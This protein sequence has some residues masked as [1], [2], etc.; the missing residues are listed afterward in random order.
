M[1]CSKANMPGQ[2]G[3][4]SDEDV[5]LSKLKPKSRRERKRWNMQTKA[6]K[7]N[8]VWDDASDDERPITTK[9]DRK[10]ETN[11]NK[12][13]SSNGINNKEKDLKAEDSSDDEPLVKKTKAPPKAAEERKLQD[14][15]RKDLKDKESSDDEP[16]VKIP[17][18]SSKPAKKT[19]SR[20]PKKSVNRKRKESVDDDD[21]DG[22][23]VGDGVDNDGNSD[24]EP[25]SKIAKK[26]RSGRKAPASPN[27][28]ATPVKKSTRNTARKQVKYVEPS[29][30]S[31]DD[32]PVAKQKKTTKS[33][34]KNKASPKVKKRKPRGK[35]SKG[36]SD[37]SSDYEPSISSAK[38]ARKCSVATRRTNK[39]ASASK[40]PRKSSTAESSN[41]SSDDEPLVKAGKH[42]QITKMLKIILPK[43]DAE[44]AGTET[45]PNQPSTGT[46][47]AENP[48]TEEATRAE[49]DHSEES[50]EEG[51]AEKT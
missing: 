25:L 47:T 41:N 48:V 19:V 33:P 5:P 44:E 22:D 29:S 9:T 21:N 46:D 6:K 3:S 24:D 30:D 39:R 10:S 40:K 7:D 18:A 37:E 51:E 45:N 49:S 27:K 34:S 12:S 43:C 23:G 17:K 1:E 35:R 31:S 26:R 38:K 14:S 15:K 20:S 2:D 36:P 50:P 11:G 8:R 16:L 13:G 42:P 4:N 28:T 32:E